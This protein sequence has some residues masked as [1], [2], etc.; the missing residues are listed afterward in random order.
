MGEIGMRPEDEY[1]LKIPEILAGRDLD[2]TDPSDICPEPEVSPDEAQVTLAELAARID[3]GDAARLERGELIARLDRQGWSQAEI[4]AASGLTQQA[5]SKSLAKTPGARALESNN[6][7]A[8]LAGRM[9]GVALHL[10]RTR[11]GMASERLA[12]KM[13]GH[14]HPVTD[15]TIGQLRHL[16][17]KDL[18]LPGIPAAYAGA[19]ADIADRMEQAG[20]VGTLASTM[21][22]RGEL[23]LGEHHQAAALT[24]AITAARKASAN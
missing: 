6:A 19:L 1:E 11:H 17:S 12:D 2:T 3:D 9:L 5:V 14:R 10:A 21:P 15:A 13:A 20:P 22:V 4:A 23:M 24:R 8:Y 7:I 18:G 16:L